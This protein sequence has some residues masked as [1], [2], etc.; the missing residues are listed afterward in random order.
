MN[1]VVYALSPHFDIAKFELEDG[2]V[3]QAAA[4]LLAAPSTIT[5]ITV[6]IATAGVVDVDTPHSAPS[7]GAMLRIA[8]DS[9]SDAQPTDLAELVAD[10]VGVVAAWTVTTSV[11]AERD[12]HWIGSSTPGVKL[13]A[14]LTGGPGID[15]GS[16]DGWLRD[17]AM[18]VATELD[19][20]GVALLSPNDPLIGDERF[21]TILELSFPG[22]AEL[23]K[24]LAE[25]TLQPILGS[26]LLDL[27]KTQLVTTAEHRLV[28]NENAWE[29]H[30]SSHPSPD[31]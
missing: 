11:L 6:D 25:D 20:V 10:V 30:N 14:F 7:F 17:A 31:A 27:G 16:Y 12:D 21:D 28:P 5:Q 26:E 15:S 19:G 1:T 2:L 9:M 22:Q 8:A 3:R 24:A 13:V 29:M 18:T 4:S 23:E